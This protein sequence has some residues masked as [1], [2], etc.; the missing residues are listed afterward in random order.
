MQSIHRCNKAH[1]TVALFDEG[2]PHTHLWL[3]I[4]LPTFLTI[5]T[6]QTK[7][8][9]YSAFFPAEEVSQSA[10]KRE[11]AIPFMP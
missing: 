4:H 8:S 1:P 2:L 6:C 7:Y 9:F 10:I 11:R 5:K 3:V